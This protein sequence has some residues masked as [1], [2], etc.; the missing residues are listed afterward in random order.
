MLLPLCWMH[1]IKTGMCPLSNVIVQI[2]IYFKQI[3]SY[4]H[5]PLKRQVLV[6]MCTKVLKPYKS[7]QVDQCLINLITVIM[8]PC[9]RQ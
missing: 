5:S 7:M 2:S 8:M 3:L 4:C 1:V 6:A 9:A